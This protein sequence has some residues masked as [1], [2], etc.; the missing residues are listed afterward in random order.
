M[1]AIDL[2]N[3]EQE[4]IRAFMLLTQSTREKQ[5]DFNSFFE[6]IAPSLKNKVQQSLYSIVI[7]EKN[8]VI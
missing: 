5:E 3:S 8:Q 4:E 6:M 1:E 2:C 7:M